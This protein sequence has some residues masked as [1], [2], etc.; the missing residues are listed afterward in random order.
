MKFVF[1]ILSILV[2]AVAA[3]FSLTESEKFSSVQAER[4]EIE[5]K[6]KSVT[7]SADAA[8]QKMRD[9]DGTLA[10][11]KDELEVAKQRFIATKSN[12][13]SLKSQEAEADAQ[14]A[15]QDAEFKELEDSLAAVQAI[16]DGIDGDVTM[17]NLGERVSEM[18]ASVEAKK[19]EVDKIEGLIADAKK[20]ITAKRE[21]ISRLED[22]RESRAKR[23]Q[24]NGKV[25]RVSAVNQD[26]GFLVIGAGSNS[27]YS[28]QTAL[29]ISR[30]GQVIG[31]ATP[32]AVEPT[33]TI[34]EIDMDSLAPGV[35]IQPG[36]RVVVAKPS[37]G[38]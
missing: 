21:S 17:D 26:W 31:R 15:A 29:I 16:F 2:C 34:A 13:D 22:R 28:P 23:I 32:S 9:L 5:S 18:E 27:G 4:L 38:N 3:Y 25:A 8:E 11:S 14:L 19:E 6:N 30:G 20:D 24:L 37:A 7:A 33:Q 36:D 12:V 10:I 1:P 35:L